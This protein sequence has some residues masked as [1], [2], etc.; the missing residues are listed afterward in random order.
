MTTE[1][2]LILLIALT[3]IFAVVGIVIG[4]L[5]LVVSKKRYVSCKYGYEFAWSF[6]ESK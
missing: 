6:Y 4:I 2:Y 5:I 1:Q 3:S